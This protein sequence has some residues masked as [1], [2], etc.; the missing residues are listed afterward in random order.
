MIIF[1]AEAQTNP[2][3]ILSKSIC[4]SLARVVRLMGYVP[5]WERNSH[6]S[7]EIGASQNPSET[8]SKVII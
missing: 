2:L 3:V 5:R 6:F 4:L 8:T 1:V 7:I